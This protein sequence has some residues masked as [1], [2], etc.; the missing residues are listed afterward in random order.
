MYK[1]TKEFVFEAAHS[2][3]HLP[4]GHKCRRPHGHS[5]RVIVEVVAPTLDAN[6]FV[7]DYG[8]LG[9]LKDHIDANLD[10]RDLNEVFPGMATTAENLAQRLYLWCSSHWPGVVAVSVSETTKTWAR[11]SA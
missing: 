11:Y 7:V 3:P 4:E 6:G 2:L 10:H 5:Y 8:D 9:I 1:I